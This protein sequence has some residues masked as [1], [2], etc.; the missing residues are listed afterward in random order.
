MRKAFLIALL[1]SGTVF[2]WLTSVAAFDATFELAKHLAHKYGESEGGI[3]K[4]RRYVFMREYPP[5]SKQFYAISYTPKYKGIEIVSADKFNL[6]S[7]RGESISAS[8]S[9]FVLYDIDFYEK[10]EGEMKIIS[11]R[12]LNAGE[13]RVKAASILRI[14]CR[15]IK[16]HIYVPIPE[17][18]DEDD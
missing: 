1:I 16:E 15:F 3:I 10:V 14:L 2:I 13:A 11:S 8:K 4:P 5:K 9:K 17:E 6:Y 18:S 7:K 12:S